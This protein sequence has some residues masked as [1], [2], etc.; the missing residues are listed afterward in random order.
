MDAVAEIWR[1]PVRKTKFSLSVENKQTDAGRDGRTR[2]AKPNSQARAGTGEKK[3]H[4]SDDHEQ[5][6]QPYTRLIHTLL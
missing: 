5:D 2:L 4:F 1:N 6:C 3:S